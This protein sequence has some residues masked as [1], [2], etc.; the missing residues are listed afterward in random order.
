MLVCNLVHTVLYRLVASVLVVSMLGTSSIPPA[1]RLLPKATA[2][3]LGMMEQLGLLKSD[4]TSPVGVRP[5]VPMEMVGVEGLA[6]GP[7]P[8]EIFPSI[9]PDGEPMGMLLN[10]AAFDEFEEN[11]APPTITNPFSVSRMQSAYTRADAIGSTLVITFTVTNNQSPVNV[12]DIP[13]GATITDT[14]EAISAIDWDN[15]PNTIH[16]VLLADTLLPANATFLSANP[17]PDQN[18]EGLAWN[19]GDVPPLGS[20]TATLTVKLPGTGNDFVDLD[21]GVAAWGT[22]QGRAVSASAAP[23]SLAPDGF[24]EWL[25]W[26]VDANYYDEYMVRKAA[27]LSNDWQQ[28]FAYVRSLGYESYKGSLRG[29]RGTLWS[30][31]GNSLDQASLLIAMLRGSGIPAR[32]RHGTLDIVRAQQLILSMFPEPEGIIGHIPPGTE[33]ADPANDPQLLAEAV[34]HWWAEAYVDGHWTDLDPCFA[35]ANAGDTFY[36]NLAGDGTDQIAEVPDSLRHKVTI[37][38]KVEQHNPLYV[39]SNA[40][41][42]ATTYPLQHTFYTVELVGRPVTLGHL[43]NS[44]SQGGAVFYYVRHTYVPYFAVSNSEQL[45][46]GDPFQDLVSNF[47]FGT[48][49][50]TGEWLLFDVCDA[51][52]NVEH[53]ERE[54]V[55][56]VGFEK[57]RTGGV[58]D[59]SAN[60]GAE[61]FV[62]ALDKFTVDV[63]PSKIP[64]RV[65][66]SGMTAMGSRL[67]E[68]NSYVSEISDTNE[69]DTSPPSE[70]VLSQKAEASTE[71]AVVELA[72]LV[73]MQYMLLTDVEVDPIG[74]S[75]LT[76][77][78]FDSANLIITSVQ[79]QLGVSD[80]KLALGIDL[81]KD[82]VRAVVYP[83]QSAMAS[84]SFQ[85]FRGI[86]NSGI[87]GSICKMIAP[88]Q[89]LHNNTYEVFQAVF[90]QGGEAVLVT[91][92][93]LDVLTSLDISDEA[94]ARILT[95]IQGGSAIIVPTSTVSIGGVETVGWWQVDPIT[96]ET[97]GVM[98]DGSHASFA[99]NAL[100]WRTLELFSISKKTLALAA[101]VV[102]AIALVVGALYCTLKLVRWM[103]GFS[104][105]LPDLC[106]L[107]LLNHLPAACFMIAIV[108]FAS[109]LIASKIKDE[110]VKHQAEAIALKIAGLDVL[111][112]GAAWWHHR[113]GDPPLPSS[114]LDVPTF[115]RAVPTA[116]SS[117]AS[118]SSYLD[119]NVMADAIAPFATL[120]SSFQS[121][122]FFTTQ[123]TLKVTALSAP[124]TVLYDSPGT[125]LGTGTIHAT[126]LLSTT[127]TLAQGTPLHIALSGHG[128]ASTYAPAL[129]GL[130]AGTDWLTYTAQL[131]ST[132]PYT[133][134]LYDAAVT[135]N[136]A[137][138]YTGDFTLVV[139]GATVITG[140]GH[141]AAPNFAGSAAMQATGADLQ[142]GPATLL[143][144]GLP[145]DASNGF[146]LAGYTGPITI[147]EYS[148]DLDLVELN[149]SFDQSLA[150]TLDPAASTIAPVQSTAFDAVI[151][152][153]LDDTYTVTVEGPPGWN[154][155][156]SD[157]GAIV[158]TP[159]P[160]AAPGD[161]TLLVTAQSVSRPALIASALH[162]VTTTPYSGLEMDVAP[163]PLITVPWGPKAEGALPGDTNNGQLQL[164]DAAYTIHVTNTSTVAHLFDIAVSGDVPPDWLILSTDHVTL[165]A[166]GS[167]QVGLYI[168]PTVTTLPPPGTE[169]P[170]TVDV[171]ATDD[172]AL[173]RTDADLFVVPAIAFNHLTADPPLL[174]AA[175]GLTAT[176]DLALTNVGNVAGT[177]PIAATLPPGWTLSNLQSP[178][179]PPAKPTPNKSP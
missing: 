139:T 106:K 160:G 96:G 75:L 37:S 11:L 29:T 159:P 98:E 151:A 59:I 137:E 90:Q 12:P 173:S 41:G 15:D 175:P 28:I 126:P 10:A 21:T 119:Q 156:I 179:F 24:A 134:I 78:Y 155:E 19:L 118:T 84:F 149:G 103:Q 74:E 60:V 102:A 49:V 131:T 164:P 46:E 133:L 71:R 130:A 143:A 145:F 101:F 48:F 70:Q 165:P 8:N 58:L 127:V 57:R 157:T 16:N 47:P 122:W 174:Y 25:I 167:G 9:G 91:D 88:D 141:T 18:S 89:D 108:A 115:Y 140:S 76:K 132:Q 124:N 13:E 138:A 32:Y 158:A 85:L 40:I 162:T 83:G 20:V 51:Y 14:I 171:T 72:E 39:Q 104:F 68:V 22:L 150:L 3:Y 148:P 120:T 93:N 73:G 146:A 111:C 54:I 31:A 82:D 87:E 86:I 35:N 147:S 7:R 144:G 17:T 129:P 178:I 168:S 136:G 44:E 176:F 6:A 177:F 110:E 56:R 36:N 53:Y 105:S 45:I 154:V 77:S 23:A 63:V 65:L 4:P 30:E 135:V 50:T 1:V 61:P 62:T 117:L 142:L 79:A 163:D 67:K 2:A 52:G 116:T 128:S 81:R 100:T 114:C 43:V 33:V 153:N 95:A 161:Y 34:D 66:E 166:G 5:A 69:N 107:G 80:T 97:V 92:G 170:F 125:L 99:E 112:A 42:L 38:L 123:N 169:Y 55:D 94:K 26:T 64:A 109:A 121:T 27:E 113:H 152:S 172:P